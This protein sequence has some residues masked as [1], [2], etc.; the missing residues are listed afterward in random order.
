[1]S[2]WPGADDFPALFQEVVWRELRCR[3]ALVYAPPPGELI[4]NV[5]LVPFVGEECLLVRLQSGEWTPPGGALEPGEDYLQALR[6]ELWEEAGARLRT[7]VPLGAW[8][9]RSSAATPYRAH[10]PH[11]T[12]YRLVGYGA[13]EVVGPPQ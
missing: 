9:C 10:Q 11:P 4:A 8:H 7:F 1:M 2:D 5:N 13:V 3:F 6:R 12:F